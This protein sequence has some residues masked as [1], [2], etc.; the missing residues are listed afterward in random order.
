LKKLKLKNNGFTIIE[1]LVSLSILIIVLGAVYSTFF[2]VNRALERFNDVPL[3]YHEVR[4][5]LDIIR[6]EI[7][8]SFVQ[9]PASGG[10]TDEE[11]AIMTP[12]S[13]VDKDIF[14]KTASE[15]K[16]TA[17]SFKN[18]GLNI[19]SY[20][21]E[22]GDEG[23]ILMKRESPLFEPS[24]GYS[25]EMIEGI[26]SFTVETLH[27]KEWIKVWDAEA[28]GLPEIVRVTIK[29]NDNGNM[30]KLMEYAAPLIGRTI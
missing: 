20:S 19:I 4:T 1:V 18:S 29:F 10:K 7:E 14:G 17:F 2:T 13:F 25:L 27:K 22:E 9:E 6:R 11:K 3:K 28:G 16:F 8:G 12:F 23:L 30:I 21:V 24:E 5:A 26:E 15:L